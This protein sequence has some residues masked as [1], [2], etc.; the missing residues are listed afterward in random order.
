MFSENFAESE[1]YLT[2]AVDGLRE[3]GQ[4]ILLPNGLLTRAALFRHKKE[5][6]KSW[7]D[8]DEAR[9]IAEYGQMKLHLTDYRLEAARV[10]RAQ[11]K[12]GGKKKKFAIIE[13]GMEKTLD[14]NEMEKRF[15]EHVAAAGKLIEETGYHR[16][17]AELEELKK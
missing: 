9:E 3:A 15:K 11:L 13:D 16:R 1:K 2:Q 10:I 14:K 6:P 7:A 17:D 4:Q 5:F 12:A 8:L